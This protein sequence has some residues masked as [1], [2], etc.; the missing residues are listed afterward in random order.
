MCRHVYE[1]VGAKNCP[2]CGKVTH[3]VDW[4]EQNQLMREWKEANPNAKSEG[5]WSI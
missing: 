1:N 2:D 4:K 3:E 5:W